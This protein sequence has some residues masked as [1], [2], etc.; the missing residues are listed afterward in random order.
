[1]IDNVKLLVYVLMW[2][3]FGAAANIYCKKYL[4]LSHDAITLTFSQYLMGTCLTSF[5]YI[6]F[7][8]SNKHSNINKKPE[9]KNS[10]KTIIIIVSIVNGFGHLMTNFSM[11]SAEVSFTHTIKA[12][13]PLFSYILV[14]YIFKIK[15]PTFLMFLSLLPIVFGIVLATTTE[16]HYSHFGLITAMLSN[17]AFSVRN[18]FSKKLTTNNNLQSTILTQN[19]DLKRSSSSTTASFNEFFLNFD[20]YK[21]FICLSIVGVLMIFPLYILQNALF[22]LGRFHLFDHDDTVNEIHHLDNLNQFVDGDTPQA[23]DISNGFFLLTETNLLLIKASCCHF[24]YNLVSFLILSNV[25]P[26][27]HAVTNGMRRIFIIFIAVIVFKN[28]ISYINLF[29]TVVACI[30]VLCYSISVRLNNRG[31]SSE[32]NNY[33]NR[34]N[35]NTHISIEV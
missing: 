17:L 24:I 16:L 27:S 26:V 14:V 18:I 33:L 30:G 6:I 12:A 29:G 35:S 25:S 31:E 34:S 21:L 4:L 11:E 5:Y 15:K 2:Y 13:E 28:P 23:I 10:M 3:G 20:S 7:G 9:L 19:K 8:N 1:M 22:V 32:R